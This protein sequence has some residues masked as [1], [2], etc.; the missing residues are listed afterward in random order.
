M[1]SQAQLN[2]KSGTMEEKKDQPTM[3]MY[4]IR[5]NPCRV[6]DQDDMLEFIVKN[7]V[8]SC[9]YGHI[10]RYRENFLRNIQNLDSGGQDEYFRKLNI[11]DIILVQFKQLREVLIVR[12]E[13]NC[14]TKVFPD[15]FINYESPEA[16]FPFNISKEVKSE[17]FE[18]F[19]PVYRD[20]SIL[21]RLQK[22]NWWVKNSLSKISLDTRIEWI[23]NRI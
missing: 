15:F 3:T 13:S 14:K 16:E 12:V 7:K 20:I 9:P 5:Q 4:A 23:R 10:G 2:L 22:P 6:T 21:A 19:S 1:I 11:G 17:Y 8:I 18:E